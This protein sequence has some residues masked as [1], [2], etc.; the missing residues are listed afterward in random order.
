MDSRQALFASLRSRLV[1]SATMVAA[2]AS[3]A[4]SA[5]QQRPATTFPAI[6]MRVVGGTGNHLS[7]FI[8]GDVYLNVYTDNLNNPAASLA[9]IYDI[10]RSLIHDNVSALTTSN[11]GISFMREMFVEYPLWEDEARHFYLSSRFA[12]Y[13]QTR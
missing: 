8:S 13:A 5:S 9:A 3:S 11:I 7:T 6:R 2:V 4:I 10:A 12:F 1:H